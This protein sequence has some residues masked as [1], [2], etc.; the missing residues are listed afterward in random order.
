MKRSLADFDRKGLLDLVHDLYAASKDNQAF[1]HARF[2]RTEDALAPYKTRIDRWMWPDPFRRQDP[3]HLEAQRAIADY[4]NAPDSQGM[5]E[6]IV[7]SC[8]QGTGFC[9][10]LGYQDEPYLNSLCGMFEQALLIAT[11]LPAAD[12]APFIVRLKGARDTSRRFGH[13]VEDSM[14]FLLT[15]YVKADR[16]L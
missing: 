15:K 10:D 2:G 9:A 5:A 16:T 7:F 1:L 4:K 3:S 12:R 11:K 14:D 6:L 13:G 8:E